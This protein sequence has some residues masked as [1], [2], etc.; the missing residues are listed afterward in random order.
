MGTQSR[1]VSRVHRYVRGSS[2]EL[3]SCGST[4]EVSKSLPGIYENQCV[5]VV[6]EEDEKVQADWATDDEDDTSEVCPEVV[7]IEEALRRCTPTEKTETVARV[8]ETSKK[9]DKDSETIRWNRTPAEIAKMQ[10]EDEA[11]AQ[12]F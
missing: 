4:E 12:V 10:K 1:T 7:S 8:D 11:I 5:C 6:Q 9:T 3:E 2:A